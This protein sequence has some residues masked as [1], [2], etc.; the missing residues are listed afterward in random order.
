MHAHDA[1]ERYLILDQ[2]G[3]ASRAFVFDARGRQLAAAA[4]EIRARRPDELRAEYDGGALWASIAAAA[5]QALAAA[6]GPVAAAGLATQRS[7]VACW[8]RTSGEPLGPVIS[9]QD[10]RAWRA[11][12]ALRPHEKRIHERTG[13]FLTP[14]YGASKLRWC[15][16][17]LPEVRR[18]REEGRLGYGPMAA[19]LA[20]RLAGG[21]ARAADVVNASRTQ[22]VALETR[23]WD[24]ELLAL[25]GLPRD[26][27]PPVVPN[28]WGYGSLAAAPEVPLA[29][30]TGDQNAALF[31]YG[32]LDE[33]TAYVNAGTGAFV[34][35]A[36]GGRLVRAG[37]LLSGVLHADGE[38]VEYVL[39]GTVNGAGSA[40]AWFAREYGVA[41]LD[42][43]LPGW[44]AAVPA[45]PV[46]FLNGVSGLGSPFWRARFPVRFEGGGGLA[47]KAVAV[48]ES[49]VFMLAVNLE[50]QSR[51]LPA[52]K[53]LRLTGG[54]ANLGGLA[55]R[56]ADLTGLV[57]E[58][59][60]GL[61]ATARGA[62]FLLAGRPEDWEAGGAPDVFEPRPNPA[63]AANY[64][65]WREAVERELGR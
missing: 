63:L 26:P 25:F 49:V 37:R 61:E 12:E 20:G 2:G 45:S 8:D 15:L 43:R 6:P 47:E 57:V 11:V 39:E 65:R 30:V 13:L 4:R 34:L 23:D 60:P 44:L 21:A 36:T 17:H 48:V 22:L 64:E 33:E 9:W 40:L 3:H 52:P 42:E 31:A 55:Q 1:H 27:L 58:R 56:L 62:A 35:R 41:D 59:P 5:A 54:L 32:E 51:Y 14:H 46:L 28:V 19:W 38:R 24:D 16:D 29:L 10:R 53:R 7:N 18:A 50:E